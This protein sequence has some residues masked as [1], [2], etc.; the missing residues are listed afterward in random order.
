MK[1]PTIP[2]TARPT[3][4]NTPPTRPLLLQ[5]LDYN[6]R[7]TISYW[8][9]LFT[10]V[11]VPKISRSLWRIRGKRRG[12]DLSER[13]RWSYIGDGGF[14]S[15]GKRCGR[16]RGERIRSQY[17]CTWSWR[18]RFCRRRWWRRGDRDLR[19]AEIALNFRYSIL[20]DHDN[21]DIRSGCNR[22]RG[23]KRGFSN[24]R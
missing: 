4:V 18:C 24:R 11:D 19:S 14:I 22:W 15:Y 1:K 7:I 23:Q 3:T 21:Q 9:V 8:I 5:K 13:G 12:Y 6:M 2:T 20:A 16:D 10:N 17:I